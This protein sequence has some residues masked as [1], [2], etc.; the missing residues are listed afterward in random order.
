MRYSWKRA[1]V[2]VAL[3]L[4]VEA[5]IFVILM[6]GFNNKDLPQGEHH[7]LRGVTI[8]TAL[9]LTLILYVI[10]R[11]GFFELLTASFLTGGTGGISGCLVGFV[12]AF[13]LVCLLRRIKLIY[14]FYRSE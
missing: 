11:K 5:V 14:E 8:I 3:F 6:Y 1:L 10:A 13:S 4:V 9:A 7:T 12:L 2:Y